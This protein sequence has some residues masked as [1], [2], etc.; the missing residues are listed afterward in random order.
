M[1]KIAVFLLLFC[2]ALMPAQA[3]VIDE[4]QAYTPEQLLRYWHRIIACG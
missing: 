3:E 4:T 1:K 2:L